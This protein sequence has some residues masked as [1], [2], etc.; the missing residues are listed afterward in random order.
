MDDGLPKCLQRRWRKAAIFSKRDLK[1][2]KIFATGI[3]IN[4]IN[5]LAFQKSCFISPQ[6]PVF[7]LFLFAASLP[8][9]S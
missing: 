3:F 2:I 6:H 8:Q 4:T 7:L 9:H 1:S 5:V